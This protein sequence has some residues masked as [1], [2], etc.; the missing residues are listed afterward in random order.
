[1]KGGLDIMSIEGS[2][3]LLPMIKGYPATTSQAQCTDMSSLF[4]P[5]RNTVIRYGAPGVVRCSLSTSSSSLSLSPANLVLINQLISAIQ[6]PRI[7]A[8]TK[9]ANENNT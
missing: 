5:Y 9:P 2:T 7:V 6:I 4:F 1:V 8:T 3:Y